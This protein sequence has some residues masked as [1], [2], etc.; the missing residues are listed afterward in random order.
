VAT[1]KSNFSRTFHTISDTREGKARLSVNVKDK[2][3]PFVDTT[4]FTSFGFGLFQY[5]WVLW[6]FIVR[7]SRNSLQRL[8]SCCGYVFLMAS[9][10][11][12]DTL[13]YL[14]VSE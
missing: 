3:T 11:Q 10:R 8:V 2:R 14:Y 9:V 4:N 12:K 5:A 7:A 6:I 13:V 1:A